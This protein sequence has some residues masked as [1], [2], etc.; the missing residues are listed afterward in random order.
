MNYP[1]D[2]K[3]NQNDS[4]SRQI[5]ILT[6]LCVKAGKYAIEDPEV[7]LTLARKAAEAI[8]LHVFT[9][10]IGSP[11]KLMLDDLIKNLGSKKILSRRML[12]LL[13]TIQ[14]FGNYGSH[15][16]EDCEGI[17]S[18]FVTPCLV[19][20]QQLT[21]W[22]FNKYLK[23]DLPFELNDFINKAVYSSSGDGVVPTNKFPDCD[24]ATTDTLS[25][26]SEQNTFTTS[27]QERNDISSQSSQHLPIGELLPMLNLSTDTLIMSCPCELTTAMKANQMASIFYGNEAVPFERYSQWLSKNPNVLVCLLDQQKE[28]VG[29]FDVFPLNA[30]FIDGFVSGITKEDELSADHILSPNEARF[31]CQL[32][33]GGIAVKSP[34][35]F[36][37][38]RNVSILLWGLFHYLRSFYPEKRTRQLFALGSTV[39]GDALLR[40]FNFTIA[41]PAN[42][43]KD[44]HNLYTLPFTHSL[45]DSYLSIMPEWNNTCR[46]S[47]ADDDQGNSKLRTILAS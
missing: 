30:N 40:K 23:I 31:C 46:L 33:L 26:L 3:H 18:E 15:H 12:L 16:Q 6:N 13:S 21:N 17:D 24:A 44:K 42:M 29:Y 5:N 20:L 38:H 8:C 10:E 1:D 9:L 7:S 2:N 4:L 37:G 22:Y 28:V 32:Y 47:W 45:L 14:V 19:S 11:G 35:S 25:L 41:S 43:R 34:D 27:V 39:E 36:V